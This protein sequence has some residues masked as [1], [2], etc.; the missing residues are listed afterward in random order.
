MNVLRVYQ[1]YFSGFIQCVSRMF[2][3]CFGGGCLK[4]FSWVYQGCFYGVLKCFQLV[5]EYPE[6]VS[7]KYQGCFKCIYMAFQGF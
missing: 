7:K 5:S 1:G 2:G 6:A 4:G 3:G